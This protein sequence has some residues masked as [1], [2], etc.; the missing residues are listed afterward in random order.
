MAVW[1]RGLP[2]EMR[3]R[4]SRRRGGEGSGLAE[5]EAKGRL[6]SALARYP[7]PAPPA[8]RMRMGSGRGSTN[9]LKGIGVQD[10]TPWGIIPM[11]G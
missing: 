5:R 6:S 4:E 3:L 2:E 7:G 10:L 1:V 9:T 8:L 11:G